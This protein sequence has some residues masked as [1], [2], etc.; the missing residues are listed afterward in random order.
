MPASHVPAS[1]HGVQFIKHPQVDE[2]RLD[3][4]L[5]LL[6]PRTLEVRLLNESAVVLWDALG[7]FPTAR[8]LAGLLDEA[9][10]EISPDESLA[11][12]VAFLDELAG[13]GFVERKE[14]VSG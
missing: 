5:I 9:N 13:A 12:V 7:E 11:L 10:P 6:H 8:E 4:E 3:D 1:R 14:P 2:E